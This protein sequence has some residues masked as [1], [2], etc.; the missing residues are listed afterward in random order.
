VRGAGLLGAIEF[1]ADLLQ[2]DAGLPARVAAEARARGVLTRV[3]RGV[4]LQ[5]SPPFVIT[6][7]E[8]AT[9]GRVFG[10][11]LEAA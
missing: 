6:E 4:A 7:D 8:I 9:I 11:S 5:V 2:E 1:R 3:V 10:E